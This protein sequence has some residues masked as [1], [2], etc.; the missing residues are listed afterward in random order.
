MS[1]DLNKVA[2][3][4]GMSFRFLRWQA[5]TAQESYRV[6]SIPKRNGRRRTIEAPS[7]VLKQIQ[8]RILTRLLPDRVSDN[9]TAFVRGENIADNARRHLGQ[10]VVL[11]LDIKD[12]FPS[13]RHELLRDYLVGNGFAPDAARTLTALC[14]FNGHLPQG[15]VTSPHLANLLLYDFDQKVARAVKHASVVYTRY[16]DDL[17]FSGNLS[18]E[19]I[20]CIIGLCRAKLREIGLKLNPE[21]TRVA[22]RGTRQ[23][24]TGLV[25][26]DKLQAPRRMRRKLRQEMHYLNRFWENEWRDLTSERLNSLLGKVNFVW[27]IDRDN[28]EFSEY[29]RQL[30]EIKSRMEPR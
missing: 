2:N 17:T 28:A 14:T 4:L 1:V 21:K 26:N 5:A 19:D 30:L 25:V 12:F 16:A 23:Q 15:A 10:P 3:S 18:E 24:V 27:N 22:R 7:V 8:R 11:E 20:A 6:Y 29:R 13:L 9:A